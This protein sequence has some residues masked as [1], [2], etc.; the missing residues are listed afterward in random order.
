MIALGLPRGTQLCCG[1]LRHASHFARR[2][3][4]GDDDTPEWRFFAW[5][6]SVHVLSSAIRWNQRHRVKFWKRTLV[7]DELL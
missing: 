5:K 3:T 1:G 2:F 4:S 7:H 6:A